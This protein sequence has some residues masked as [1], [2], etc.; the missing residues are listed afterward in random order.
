[1]FDYDVVTNEVEAYLLGFIYAD[2][3]ITQYQYGKY[4]ALQIT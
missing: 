2:G 1:M 3:C 4:R